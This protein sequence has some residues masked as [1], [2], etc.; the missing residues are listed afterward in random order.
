MAEVFKEL[1]IAYKGKKHNIKLKFETINKI[2]MPVVAGG[3]GISLPGLITRANHGDVPITE[4]ARI[5]SYLLQTKDVVVS[6]EEMYVELFTSED[7]S[8]REYVNAIAAASFP[9]SKSEATEEKDKKD[10]K[11]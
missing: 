4:I 9:L 11:K 10:K 6:D 1:S 8:I 2:E 3:L 5:L 7:A